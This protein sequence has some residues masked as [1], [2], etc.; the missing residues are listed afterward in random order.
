MG[1]YP[2]GPTLSEEKGREDGIR[3][4]GRGAAFEMQI[5]KEIKT[6]NPSPLTYVNYLGQNGL[7]AQRLQTSMFPHSLGLSKMESR[8]LKTV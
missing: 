3:D 7:G 6:N 2:D 8:V 5:N 1:R 4:S